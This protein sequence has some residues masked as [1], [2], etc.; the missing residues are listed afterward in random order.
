MH[1]NGAIISG[2]GPAAAAPPHRLTERGLSSCLLEKGRRP[3][4][5]AAQHLGA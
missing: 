5:G 3:P 2:W 4:R 1:E